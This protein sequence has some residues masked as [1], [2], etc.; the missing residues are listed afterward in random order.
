MCTPNYCSPPQ[1]G[2]RTHTLVEPSL[3]F[4]HTNKSF[5]YKEWCHHG[6]HGHK[7]LFTASTIIQPQFHY[8]ARCP[9]PNSGGIHLII[10]PRNSDVHT[11]PN[12][13]CV[14]SAVQFH[15]TAGSPQSAK[16]TACTVSYISSTQQG[17][18]TRPS[19]GC[20]QTLCYSDTGV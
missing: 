19:L 15:H 16:F 2:A 8:T 12:L 7:E 20:V 3:G 5:N 1:Q 13:G 6:V 14:H 10:V 17:V 11:R 4:E 18:H 9:R